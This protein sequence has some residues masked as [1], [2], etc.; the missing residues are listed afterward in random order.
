VNRYAMV[1][2]GAATSFAT[3]RKIRARRIHVPMLSKKRLRVEK[4]EKVF[5]SARPHNGA[6]PNAP[7][8]TEVSRGRGRGKQKKCEIVHGTRPSGRNK[9]KE[10]RAP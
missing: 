7:T 4:K 10:K 1:L 2:R 3:S 6:V 5:A 8:M 9:G